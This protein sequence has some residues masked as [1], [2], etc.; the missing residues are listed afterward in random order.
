MTKT[1]TKEVTDTPFQVRSLSGE[2]AA[3]QHVIVQ[4]LQF[5]SHTVTLFSAATIDYITQEGDSKTLWKI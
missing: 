2:T 5:F 3:S 1:L 4:F